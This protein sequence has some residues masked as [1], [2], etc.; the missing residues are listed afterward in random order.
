MIRKP[1]GSMAATITRIKVELDPP[2]ETFNVV[3]E[4]KGGVWHHSAGS[5]YE[6]ELFLKGVQA[7]CA[8]MGQYYSLPQIPRSVDVQIRLPR[9]TE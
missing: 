3:F 5:T 9:T 2:L 6:L 1:D 7:G 4:T 8:M